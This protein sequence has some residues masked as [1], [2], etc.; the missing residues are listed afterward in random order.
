MK[1][2]DTHVYFWA[3]TYSNWHPAAI[4]DVETGKTFQNTEQAF[5][6]YKALHFGDMETLKKVEQT[7]NPREVKKLGR[8]V[9]NYD[10][11]EWAKVRY[12]IMR[13]VNWWKFTQIAEYR[14]ELL[15]TGNRVIVE[16]SPYDKIWG[17]GLLEDDPLILD[18]KNWQGENLLGKVIMDVRELLKIS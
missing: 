18:E 10:D 8:E 12:D 6:W 14:D 16:A 11:A 5:M 1:T 17:V 2:T 4:T 13:K 9:K 15:A 3:G 7:P